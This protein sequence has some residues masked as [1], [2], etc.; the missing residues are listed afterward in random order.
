LSKVET[1]AEAEGEG[2]EEEK[3]PNPLLPRRP[4]VWTAVGI[5][6]TAHMAS[7]LWCVQRVSPMYHTRLPLTQLVISRSLLILR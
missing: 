7:S 5:G 4:R 1:E 6:D 3:N 2:V